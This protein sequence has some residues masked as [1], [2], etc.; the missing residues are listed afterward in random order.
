MNLSQLANIAEFVGGIAVVVTLVYL[1]I[2]IRQT[3]KTTH[4][5]AVATL[6]AQYD[7]PNA[8]IA[9]NVGTARAFRLGVEGSAEL[10]PDE[11]M[12]FQVLML[13]FMAVLH[14][15]YE[16]RSEGILTEAQWQIYRRDIAEFSGQPGVRALHP[17]FHSYYSPAPG[18]V[19]ELKRMESENAEN[20]GLTFIEAIEK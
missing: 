8:A 12:Q 3:S 17:Y 18:F 16:F 7:S 10:N 14:T 13:Q 1:A 6:L 9:T 19:D 5:S 15:A 11:K 4:A 2:Q 20:A